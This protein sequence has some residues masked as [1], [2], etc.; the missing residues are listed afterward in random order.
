MKRMRESYMN[1]YQ[2]R[3]LL[4]S[5]LGQN[6][7]MSNP[8]D[9]IKRCVELA[10]KDM[11]SG[12]RFVCKKFKKKVKKDRVNYT[13]EMLENSD[14]KYSSVDKT[15]VCE[16]IFWKCDEIRTIQV[17]GKE[18][19]FKPYGLAQKL[20]NMTFKYL[21]IYKDYIGK[22]IDFSHCEC[23][24]DSVVLTKLDREEK[25]TN[26][27][28]GEYNEIRKCIKEALD[29]SKYSLLKEEIG[30][31]VFDDNWINT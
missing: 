6:V 8:A 27:T 13:I 23:P 16:D 1:D 2:I 29:S 9:V 15:K 18:R 17:N 5:V 20:I 30:E 10:D 11:M 4:Q 7:K 14:Y 24:V 19:V 3:F 21:Y 12:G 26:I 31:L 25:W 28:I 22:D